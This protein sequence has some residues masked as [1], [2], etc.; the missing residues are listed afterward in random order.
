MID[1]RIG[2]L[3]EQILENLKQPV[4]ISDMAES[5][6]VSIDYF[7][8]LFKQETGFTPNQFI[9]TRRLERAK[10]LLETTNLR[11]KEISSQVGIQDQSH[12]VRDFKTKYGNKPTEYRQ[13]HWE[14]SH[15][16]NRQ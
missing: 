4:S 5:A 13:K 11:V 3:V 8:K 14:K 16:P 9:R 15:A 2:N 1:Y 12:F 7:Y 6:N 10:E